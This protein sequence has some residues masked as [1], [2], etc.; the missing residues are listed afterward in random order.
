MKSLVTQLNTRGTGAAQKKLIKIFLH[1][2][3]LENRFHAPLWFQWKAIT[4]EHH[5]LKFYQ[6]CCAWKSGHARY[7][8]DNY[9]PVWVRQCRLCSRNWL[10]TTVNFCALTVSYKMQFLRLECNCCTKI[11]LN[12]SSHYVIFKNVE[13]TSLVSNIFICRLV[14]VKI[15]P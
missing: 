11:I 10:P 6:A 7:L 5:T 3:F 1:K 13:Q 2:S 14:H 4:R 12:D 15:F 8:V 9:L